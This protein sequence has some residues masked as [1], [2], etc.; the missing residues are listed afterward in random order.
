MY[1][2]EPWAPKFQGYLALMCEILER[3]DDL[4]RSSTRSL[5]PCIE[6]IGGMSQ[7]CLA[8]MLTAASRGRGGDRKLSGAPRHSLRKEAL[9]RFIFLNIER[10]PRSWQSVDTGGPVSIA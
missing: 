5:K 9:L 4:L 8:V 1:R 7:V 6:R 10:V 3:R 2:F